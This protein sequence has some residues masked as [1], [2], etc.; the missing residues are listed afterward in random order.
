MHVKPFD[1]HI[2]FD[3]H[4]QLSHLPNEELGSSTQFS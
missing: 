3:G 4:Y 1:G 2:L